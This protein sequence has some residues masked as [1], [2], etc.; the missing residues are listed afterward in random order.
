MKTYTW[1]LIQYQLQG[2]QNVKWLK[3]NLIKPIQDLY[4]EKYKISLR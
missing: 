3:I 2:H 1:K 4:V